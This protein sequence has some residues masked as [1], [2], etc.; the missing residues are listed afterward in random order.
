MS[1][2]SV[3]RKK[4]VVLGGGYGGIFA[5]ASLCKDKIFDI[6]IIDKNPYHQLLQQIPYIVCGAKGTANDIT[7]RLEELFRDEIAEGFLRV[8]HAII[9]SIDLM[10]KT[11]KLKEVSDTRLVEC[12]QY[13][14]LIISLGAETH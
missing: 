5:A 11:V 9:K 4:V 6:I 7:V 13:D 2:Q 3:M 8:L 12:L 14:Y 1:D 10:S